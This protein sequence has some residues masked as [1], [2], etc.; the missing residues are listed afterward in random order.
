MESPSLSLGQPLGSTSTPDSVSGQRSRP[1]GM[2]SPSESWV[3]PVALTDAPGAVFGAAVHTVGHTVVVAVAGAPAC[4]PPAR[5]SGVS[6]QRSR[7]SSMP[8]PSLS[9]I[10][11]LPSM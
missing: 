4:R 8:S 11:L 9:G 7:F 5:P 3:Q 10:G 6:G 1:S 2:L